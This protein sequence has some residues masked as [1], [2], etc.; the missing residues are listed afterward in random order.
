VVEEKKQERAV[1]PIKGNLKKE[2]KEALEQGDL[3]AVADLA[4]QDKA[5]LRMLVSLA[6]NKDELLSWRAIEAMG[7]VAGALNPV[8]LDAVRDA[9][10][11]LL[12]SMGE[13]SGGIGWTAAE[14]LGEILRSDPEVF[15]D[16]IPIVWSFREE[17]NFR[18]GTIRA[19]GR[20]AEKRPDLTAFVVADLGEMFSDRNPEVRGH[21]AWAA[22]VLGAASL[23]EMVASLAGDG[24][25]LL[26]YREG[27]LNPVTV[28]E[29]AQEALGRLEQRAPS[30]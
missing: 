28:G 4:Q 15:S 21:A 7:L 20:V 9:V 27:E 13:E 23:R 16:I 29:L 14:M 12:W 24:E 30:A 11:R 5:V 19:M 2:V 22:G 26:F 17:E 3:E 1:R 10:R 6:Y 18:A 25:T 8:R